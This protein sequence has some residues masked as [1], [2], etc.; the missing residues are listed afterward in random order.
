MLDDRVL[1]L[2]PGLP[3]WLRRA[4]CAGPG[5][6]LRWLL[7]ALAGLFL[8]M[9]GGGGTGA[10]PAPAQALLWP[11]APPNLLRPGPAATPWSLSATGRGSW[12]WPDAPELGLRT[13]PGPAPDTV[14]ASA[15]VAVAPQTL[16]RLQ[17]RYRVDGS[18]AAPAGAAAATLCLQM[19]PRGVYGSALLAP[20]NRPAAAARCLALEASGGRRTAVLD[21]V[22][23]AG[24]ETLEVA[25]AL[26]GAGVRVW[27]DDVRL[28]RG[29]A[30]AAAGAEGAL[31]LA[32][33]AS[34]LA[35]GAIGAAALLLALAWL[36]RP[37]WRGRPLLLATISAAAAL[38]LGALGLRAAALGLLEGT[39]ARAP[40]EL[41]L[42]TGLAGGA[43]LGGLCR[44][45]RWV[46]ALVARMPAVV[47]PGPAG[48]RT[49]R[50][51]RRTGE[52]ALALGVSALAAGG[53]LV[54]VTQVAVPPVESDFARNVALAGQLLRDG[55]AVLVRPGGMD[56]RPPL[57]PLLLAGLFRL[58]GATPDAGRIGQAGLH[59]LLAGVAYLGVRRFAAPGWAALGALLVGAN[60]YLLGAVT[61]LNYEH[62]QALTWLAATVW[63]WWTFQHPRLWRFGVA[64][65]LWAVTAL[66]KPYTLAGPLLLLGGLAAW[67]GLR[68]LQT[69]RQAPERARHHLRVA[70]GP[71]L[72][73]AAFLVALLPWLVRSYLL[74]REV[75]PVTPGLGLGIW[76]TT[77]ERLPDDWNTDPRILAIMARAARTTPGA[78]AAQVDR[79]FLAEG[80]A[81]LAADPGRAARNLLG[82][83]LAR[84]LLE[85]HD[86]YARYRVTPEQPHLRGGPAVD[87]AQVHAAW[88]A[89]GLLPLVDLAALLRWVTPLAQTEHLLL[90]TLAL[91]G[92]VLALARRDGAA[93]IALAI[94]WSIFV[95]V[96]PTLAQN[97]YA[98]PFYPL[99]ALGAVYALAVV[100]QCLP[101]R[102]AWLRRGAAAAASWL[103]LVLVLHSAAAALA[104]LLLP[105]AAAAG[106]CCG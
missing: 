75:V 63:L 54:A 17:V 23:P 52:L 13:G 57:Y 74:Y 20:G 55:W 51:T 64:A 78:N 59:S 60:P 85:P 30:A 99:V 83:Q 106:V 27:L 15:P 81:R 102:A 68:A 67:H 79:L 14:A 40:L 24:A 9:V 101:A 42:A 29:M 33:G 16:Y 87:W 18:G 28:V 91:G 73:V 93:A 95:T 41:L 105:R 1:R 39:L 3:A 35:G 12:E 97:R 6:A 36:R 4:G 7:P 69:R 82:R 94:P 72:F 65:A 100:P 56:E 58:F 46:R 45:H 88:A 84:W 37:V 38:G 76:A 44:P 48:R 96:W 103:L 21:L 70:R 66:I 34:W 31:V 2:C 80:L 11:A 50:W 8:L 98:L 53:A 19:T 62:L 25:V 5:T 104:L 49:R 71:A 47:W 26:T 92:L 10:L 86:L 22:T 77:L 61:V 32:R 90:V 43:A 89:A